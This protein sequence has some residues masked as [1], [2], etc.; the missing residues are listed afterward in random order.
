MSAMPVEGPAPLLVV[1][2]VAALALWRRA[3]DG[4]GAVAG[5]AVAAAMALGVGWAGVAMLATLLVL[6]TAVSAPSSRRRR[7]TQVIGNGGIAAAAALAAGFGASWG[8]AAAAGALATA[9]SD[10]ASSELGSRFGGT[11]RAL[12]FGPA[13][14][15]GADGGMTPL[16]TAIG[17]A[18]AAPVPAVGLLLGALG[19][20]RAFA[21]ALL[22]GVLGNLADSA[23]GLLVQPRLGA[24]GN[25][26][27]NLFA[28]AAG[29]AAAVAL[30]SPAWPP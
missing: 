7:W 23:F 16:G 19:D 22:A 9:L 13:M 5:C 3:V 8:A 20:A 30:T 10:T 24:R 11:P 29:A 27:C 14:A 1:P 28:T 12:L 15:R 17:L 2:V 21:A 26:L 6:G 25:D 18:A 4:G